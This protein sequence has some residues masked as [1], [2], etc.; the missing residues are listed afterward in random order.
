ML[1]VLA[2]T[3]HWLAINK[4]AG[5]NVEQLW[6][7]PSV[8]ADVRQYLQEQGIRKPYVGIVHRLDRPVSGVLLV[9]KKKSSLKKL[10]E[11]FR[12]RKVH[13]LYHAVVEGAVADPQG[14]LTHHLVK[15]Q[16]NKRA[17]AFPKP[18][19]GSIEASLDYKVLQ[20]QESTSYLEIRPLSGKF[21][22]IRV[23]LAASGHPIVGDEKYGSTRPY[24]PNAIQLHASCLGFFD[25][26][27]AEPIHVEAPLPDHPGWMDLQV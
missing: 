2:E 25:P 21:H 13:K 11:Q 16:K 7:Y 10:N 12:D 5:L 23:Q 8:E 9:A 27:S 24:L 15:D 17:W 3:R 22:Q 19:K 26:V 20:I 1:S 14:T 18:Q 6:D 4:I